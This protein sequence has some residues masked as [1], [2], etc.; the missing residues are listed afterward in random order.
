M[1]FLVARCR[2]SGTINALGSGD[3]Q[4]RLL[5]RTTS[6]GDA[7]LKFGSWSGKR[8]GLPVRSIVTLRRRRVSIGTTHSPSTFS[9]WSL[10]CGTSLAEAD[11]YASA[12]RHVAAGIAEFEHHEPI[13]GSSDRKAGAID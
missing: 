11:T 13:S 10:D 2:G 1:A 3:P 4:A 8:V 6:S 7:A 12:H 9:L 5:G